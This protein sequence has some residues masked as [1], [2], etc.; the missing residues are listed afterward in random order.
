MPDESVALSGLTNLCAYKTA[1]KP[2]RDE[3]M[4]EVR[5]TYCTNYEHCL[6]DPAHTD[7]CLSED[8]RTVVCHDHGL[9]MRVKWANV[10]QIRT[11]ANL[12]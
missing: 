5:L 4:Y 8:E 10:T 11:L 6:R 1:G 3:A 2:C 7:E 9:V 12:S